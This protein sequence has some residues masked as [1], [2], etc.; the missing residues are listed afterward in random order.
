MCVI[1]FIAASDLF[2]LML[3]LHPNL[4]RIV[5]G[6]VVSTLDLFTDIYVAYMYWVQ[7][8]YGFFNL[9]VGMLSASMFLNFVHVFAQN[10]KLGLKRVIFEMVPALVGL[11]PA[12]DAK[13][14]TSGLKIEE[15]QLVGPLE[16]MIIT[17]NIEMFAESIPGVVIQL[18]AIADLGQA[19]PGAVTS[20][21]V[22]AL[23]T[24]FI[25]ATISYDLDTDPKNRQTNP[26]F[27]GYIPNETKKRTGKCNAAA[28]M[29][30]ASELWISFSAFLLQILGIVS[31]C[32]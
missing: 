30:L 23:S 27:Y 31:A 22:S 32:F 12:L 29:R 24:G 28:V 7:G 1:L 11:K 14:V 6:A 13:R 19:T 26:D 20:L 18:A 10:R 21:T 9:T 4:N 16:D 3:C 2:Q 5:V 8:R 15:G 17:K 25:S